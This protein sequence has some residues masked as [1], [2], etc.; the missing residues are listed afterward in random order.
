MPSLGIAS[1]AG[2]EGWPGAGRAGFTPAPGLPAAP[3]AEVGRV[4]TGGDDAIGAKADTD[5]AGT[6]AASATTAAGMGGGLG[7]TVGGA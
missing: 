6:G 7:A 2:R 1:T 3:G 4:G 5:A